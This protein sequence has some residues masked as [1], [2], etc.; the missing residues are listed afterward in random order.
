LDASRKLIN[1]TFSRRNCLLKH[2]IEK[3]VEGGIE[4]TRR[5]GTRCKQL[6]DDSK[7]TIGYRKLE[8]E[9]PDS[10]LWRTDFGRG[11]GPVVRQTVECMNE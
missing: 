6:L 4:V 1:T 10:S 5:R 11:Y 2:I 7:E 9:A 8:E 3:K